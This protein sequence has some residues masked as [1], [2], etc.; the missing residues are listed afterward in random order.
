MFN[1]NWFESNM[2]AKMI[3]PVRHSLTANQNLNV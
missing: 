2:N 3:A 1:V